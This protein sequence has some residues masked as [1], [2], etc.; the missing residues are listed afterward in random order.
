MILLSTGI[1]E[2]IVPYVPSSPNFMNAPRP[3][4]NGIISSYVGNNFLTCNKHDITN[5]SKSVFCTRQRT[6]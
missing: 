6:T 5:N 4:S 1:E 2:A 3:N